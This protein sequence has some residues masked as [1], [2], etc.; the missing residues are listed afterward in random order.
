[1]K[2]PTTADLLASLRA[3]RD[4]DQAKRLAGLLGRGGVS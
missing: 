4:A 1:M 3:S 2:P